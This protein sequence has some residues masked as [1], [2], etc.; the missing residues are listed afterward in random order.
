MI[1][2]RHFLSLPNSDLLEY[3]VGR[4]K[5]CPYIPLPCPPVVSNLVLQLDLK[6]MYNG[7]KEDRV[8]KKSV[9]SKVSAIN[10]VEWQAEPDIKCD[11]QLWR[12]DP[13]DAFRV[14]VAD[15]QIINN[16]NTILIQD[17]RGIYYSSM[18]Q[19]LED[20][21]NISNMYLSENQRVY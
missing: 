10:I 2:L 16:G 9:R 14:V 18:K 12:Y 20:Y 3:I 19:L 5:Q 7:R 6:S 8:I 15:I 21:S 4:I 1:T 17:S 13:L 11:I